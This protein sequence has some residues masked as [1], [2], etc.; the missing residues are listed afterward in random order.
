MLLAEQVCKRFGG[1]PVL[2]DL[3][4]CV[5]PGEIVGIIGA[6]GVGKTTLFRILCHLV[7]ADSG[8][9]TFGTEADTGSVPY[10]D[11]GYLPESRSL[12][13]EVTVG[14]TLEFWARLRGMSGKHAAK[15]RD[16]WLERIGL[17]ARTS[18]RVSSLSK[19]NLQ[20]L[21]LAASMLHDPGVLILDEPFSGLDPVNQVAVADLIN[22]AARQGTAVV[23][24][25]HHI[26]LLQRLANRILVLRDGQLHPAT[27]QDLHPTRI[28][29]PS[30]APQYGFSP[31]APQPETGVCE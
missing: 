2:W 21:Q 22:R 11:I 29:A 25:A 5:A 3:D 7:P 31:H 15:A 14:R 23:L 4:L 8:T 16:V 24:S 13:S 17:L 26:E 28:A 1:R 20:K 6:N 9:I 27:S 10:V 30:Q 18:H 12:F 19:G